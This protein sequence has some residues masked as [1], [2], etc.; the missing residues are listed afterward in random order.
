MGRPRSCSPSKTEDFSLRLPPSL[1][2]LLDYVRDIGLRHGMVRHWMTTGCWNNQLS[3]GN[4]E[5][6]SLAEPMQPAWAYT[7]SG[8][9]KEDS[10]SSHTHTLTNSSIPDAPQRERT[11]DFCNSSLSGHMYPSTAWYVA[12]GTHH[13]GAEVM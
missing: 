6:S 4:Q 11:L 13:T 3:Q 9:W 5:V 7:C 10:A 1:Q 8:F 2:G 12:S